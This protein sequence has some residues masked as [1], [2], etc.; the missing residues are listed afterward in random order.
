ML[1]H[2]CLPISICLEVTWFIMNSYQVY[3]QLRHII[4]KV[5]E[6]R[7]HD[8]CWNVMKSAWRL[9]KTRKILVGKRFS[10]FLSPRSLIYEASVLS[11]IT[12][13]ARYLHD[14]IPYIQKRKYLQSYYSI[15][16]CNLYNFLVFLYSVKF[17]RYE[18]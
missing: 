18:R 1:M 11:I 9:R 15:E 7:D 4:K 6:S 3:L 2:Y 8:I 16:N 14:H 5:V 12:L 17:K 13:S 10:F